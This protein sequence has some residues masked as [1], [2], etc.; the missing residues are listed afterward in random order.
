MGEN[1]NRFTVKE[2]KMSRLTNLMKTTLVVA[3]S[4]VLLTACSKTGHNS[5]GPTVQAFDDNSGSTTFQRSPSSV[6]LYGRVTTIDAGART[7]QISGQSATINVA[8]NAEIVFKDSGNET[9]IT[10]SEIGP[11]DSVEVRG[12]FQNASN[13]LADRVRKRARENGNEIEFG[14]RV[15]T[16]DASARTMTVTGRSELITVATN[17]EIVKRAQGTEMPITL[18][19]IQPGDSVD[20]RARAQSDG[21]L[22][23]RV[24]LRAVHL[25]DGVDTEVEFT[26]V[27]TAINTVAGTFTV[28]NHAETITTDSATLVFGDV[29]H[30]SD[31]SAASDSGEKLT[32]K[33][34]IQFSDLEVGNVVEVHANRV[35]A[36]TLYAVMI[37]VEDESPEFEDGQNE[38]EF[39]ALLATLNLET[40]MITFFD[41]PDTGI[42]NVSAQLLGFNNEPV[43]LAAFVGCAI[44]EVRGFRLADGTI[45]VVRFSMENSF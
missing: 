45:N 30:G 17:A 34:P 32:N 21:L 20:I 10:L 11:G 25:E 9:P 2:M 15:L 26:D 7:M 16:I 42:V 36:T 39:K 27:I 18:A 40:R 35:D 22:A 37:D 13:F 1:T 41:R 28:A 4:A 33:M 24:R 14:G 31:G 38:V 23:D 8:Q 3:A 43:A 6:D 5:L 29:R 19:D 44:V 12:D